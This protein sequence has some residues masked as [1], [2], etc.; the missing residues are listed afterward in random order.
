[1][2]FDAISH[3]FVLERWIKAK[4]FA[5]VAEV[6]VKKGTTFLHLLETCP[7]TNLFGVDIWENETEQLPAYYEKLQAAVRDQPRACLIRDRSVAAAKTFPDRFFDLVF[8]DADHAEEAV[9]ADI[10]A[11]YPKVRPGGILCGHD[12]HMETVRRA[13]DALCPGWKHHEQEIWSIPVGPPLIAFMPY[14]NDRN[15]GRA[16]NEAMSLLPEDGWGCLID[17]DVMFTTTEWHRQLTAA[18]LAKPEGCF[19]GVT[20]RIKSPYQRVPGV[21]AKNH[22]MAYHRKVGLKLALEKPRLLDVTED[23]S[24]KDQT[25]A[26]FLMVLS[27]TAWREAGGFAEGLHYVDRVMWLSLK[28]AGRRL[29][30]HKGVYLYHWHRAGGEPHQVGAW[31]PLVHHLEDGSVIKLKPTEPLPL[32]GGR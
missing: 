23:P 3:K 32:Y 28:Q 6:G 26:G 25:P 31:V 19:S 5:N 9:M 8:I 29:Y 18:I 4:R 2:T 15:L 7:E 12:V 13:V 10:A 24:G 22:D 20:N 11:W 16:Y 27:K 30:I 14:A 17:H 1:M 21:S